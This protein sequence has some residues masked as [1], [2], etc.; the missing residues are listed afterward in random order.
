LAFDVDFCSDGILHFGLYFSFQILSNVSQL[1][2]QPLGFF[3]SLW[4]VVGGKGGDRRKSGRRRGRRTSG[5]MEQ[6]V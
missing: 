1:I 4:D 6:T 3:G 5:L 2:Y